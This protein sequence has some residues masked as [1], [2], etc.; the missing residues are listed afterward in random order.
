MSFPNDGLQGK[1]NQHTDFERFPRKI[2]WMYTRDS[3]VIIPNSNR[4]FTVM[5]GPM[6]YMHT[7]I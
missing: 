7:N 1:I 2:Y 5:V 4:V 3:L 6:L